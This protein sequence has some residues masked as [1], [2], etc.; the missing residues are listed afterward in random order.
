M[1]FD[2]RWL[3]DR[4]SED[5]HGR[6]LWALGECARS[7]VSAHRRRWASGLFRDA[8]SVVETFSSPR[9]WAF[10][11]LGLDAYLAGAP[12]DWRVDRLRT[13]LADRLMAMLV[14]FEGPDWV[15]FED[16]LAY[17]NAR[18]PEALI[19]TGLAV[20][21]QGYLAAGLRA[22]RW[23][24]TVQTGPAG[25]FRPVGTESF[26]DRRQAPRAFDQQPVEAAASISAYLAASRVEA[27]KAWSVDA[28][29]AFSW[30]LGANDLWT[31]LVD[32]ETGGCRDGLH[33]DRP[34]E[35]QGAESVLSY[36]LALADMRRWARMGVER[37]Q[38]AP[39]RALSA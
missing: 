27:G 14:Q 36:L 3:E 31:V 2:R 21:G 19:L 33:P 39:S 28:D 24:A 6:T 20:Q 12:E 38:D 17:D 15:W 29:R 35:N 8:L 1:S 37:V 5:S 18:L 10:T 16:G 32:P 7:D 9:A 11:L 34:N 26:F 22:L 23:L 13:V 30:F 4:G 25:L